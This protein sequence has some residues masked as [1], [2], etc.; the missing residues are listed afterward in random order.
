MARSRSHIRNSHGVGPLLSI[1]ICSHKAIAW[2]TLLGFSHEY[3]R[4]IDWYSMIECKLW[5]DAYQGLH[6]ELAATGEIDGGQSSRVLHNVAFASRLPNFP[7]Q[8]ILT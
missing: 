2:L 5:R 7:M 6:L 8:I 1:K 3:R 4:H